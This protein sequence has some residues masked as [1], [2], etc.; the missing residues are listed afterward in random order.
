MCYNMPPGVHVR[1]IPGYD[2]V[3]PWEMLP[4]CA[5]GAFLPAAPESTEQ[6]P[7]DVGPCDGQPDPVYGWTACENP[8]RHDA[9]RMEWVQTH[10]VRTCARCKATSRKVFD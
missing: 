2:V 10:E 9:H 5:C 7:V 8:V 3:E 6:V 4:R 1:D